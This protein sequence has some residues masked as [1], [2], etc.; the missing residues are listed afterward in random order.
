MRRE[1]TVSLIEAV[2]VSTLVTSAATCTDSWTS[3]TC[4]ARSMR[5]RWLTSMTT[6]ERRVRL[7]AGASALMLYSP[8]RTSGIT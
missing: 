5:A 2:K 1:S 3:P 8:G 7:K 6:P 4:K